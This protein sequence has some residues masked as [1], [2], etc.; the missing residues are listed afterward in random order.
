LGLGE[1]GYR[2]GSAF[3]ADYPASHEGYP[4]DQYDQTYDYRPLSHPPNPPLSAL[5]ESNAPCHHDDDD[6][7]RYY[8]SLSRINGVRL[9]QTD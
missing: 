7:E 4:D 8:P 6:D 9:I 3:E 5:C 1:D 2:A